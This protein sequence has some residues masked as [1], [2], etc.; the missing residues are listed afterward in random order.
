MAGAA[1][2]KAARLQPKQRTPADPRATAGP[3]PTARQTAGQNQQPPRVLA[4]KRLGAVNVQQPPRVLALD[5]LGPAA[6][7]VVL[8]MLPS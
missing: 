7:Q 4:F 8:P 1:L 6:S 3:A 2:C 5:R